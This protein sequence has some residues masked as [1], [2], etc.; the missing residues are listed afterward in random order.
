M[1]YFR[2]KLAIDLG[3]SKITTF[4]ENKGIKVNEPCVVT[5]DTYKNKILSY[6]EKAKKLVGK[7]PGNVIVKEPILGGNIIDFDVTLAVIKRA[8]K[9]S[10]GK[11]LFR[12]NVIVCIPSEQTQIQKRAIIQ[13]TKIAGAHKVILIE[14]TIASAIACSVNV[15]ESR[16]VIVVDIGAGKTDISVI[17]NGNIIITKNLNV[18]GNSIDESI[19]DFIR[20]RYNMLIGKTSSENIKLSM[21]S[22]DSKNEQELFEVKG[23]NLMNGLP[24]HIFI[25]RDDVLKAISQI[26]NKIVNAISDTLAKTPPE[27]I[28]DIFETGLIL[29]GGCSKISYFKDFI[30]ERTRLNVIDPENPEFTVIKGAG[31]FLNNTNFQEDEIEYLDE[32]KRHVLEQKEQLRKR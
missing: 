29:T 21:L 11:N 24:M 25:S 13:A 15:N 5:M 17:S 9:K 6:G 2:K 4:V 1:D 19:S 23:R 26:L 28:A 27:L 7:L 30:K 31:K 8:I 32:L 20:T 18:A 14:Q 16:G 3:T 12:P 10:I 22:V